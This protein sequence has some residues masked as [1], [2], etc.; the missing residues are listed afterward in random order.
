[1]TLQESLI[2]IS[3][4]PIPVG[5]IEKTCIDRDLVSTDTY[6]KEIGNSENY[7][8][9]S[10]DLYMFLHNSP[11][12]KEQTISLNHLADVKSQLLQQAQA[13]YGKYNDTKFTG[14]TYGF[15][16]EDLNG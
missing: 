16:G 9:A 1:M 6:T 13:I 5:A 4:Y 3:V 2:Y 12:L 11:D 8:L 15:K 10:A 7:Q 14:R